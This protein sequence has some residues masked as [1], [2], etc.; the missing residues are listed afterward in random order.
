LDLCYKVAQLLLQEDP[1][2]DFFDRS[3]VELASLSVIADMMPQEKD[4]ADIVVRGLNSL[5]TT[6]RLALQNSGG[7]I[8][9]RKSV[10]FYICQ[11]KSFLYWELVGYH[12]LLIK[13]MFF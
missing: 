5:P 13:L 8:R 12:H 9:R 2:Y 3:F 4:N 11:R 6:S 10:D 7:K 1:E